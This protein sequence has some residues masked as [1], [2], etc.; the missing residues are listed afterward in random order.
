MVV[1]TLNTIHNLPAQD[2]HILKN[3]ANED[4]NPWYS[5]NF[6]DVLIT[7]EWQ[8]TRDQVYRFGE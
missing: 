6:G 1:S 5:I 3:P 7:P 2:I 8:F 4:G